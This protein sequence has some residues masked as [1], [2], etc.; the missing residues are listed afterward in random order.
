MTK[1]ST[2]SIV[3]QNLLT[4][5]YYSPYCG[6]SHCFTMSRVLWCPTKKQFVCPRCQW[7][8]QFPN[9][10]I[11]EYESYRKTWYSGAKLVWE[12]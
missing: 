1:M 11:A 3:Q 5:P 10:F 4:K 6:N 8:S 12:C 7:V 2:R 9:S